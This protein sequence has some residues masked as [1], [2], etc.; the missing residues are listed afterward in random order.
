M[1][2]TPTLLYILGLLPFGFA[3]AKFPPCT[4]CYKRAFVG[5]SGQPYFVSYTYPQVGYYISLY[6][7]QVCEV[8]GK[9]YW[10]LQSKGN[11]ADYIC[12]GK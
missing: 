10:K 7:P 5:T 1:G 12:N 11:N 9:Q 4:E 3:L 6:T 2:C 8:A